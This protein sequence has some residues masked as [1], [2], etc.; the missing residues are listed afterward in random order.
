MAMPKFKT[1]IQGLHNMAALAA[2][3]VRGA[4]L[5]SRQRWH[6]LVCLAVDFAFETDEAGRFIFITPDPALG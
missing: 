1:A 5:D 6:D 4:L 3:P 2:D